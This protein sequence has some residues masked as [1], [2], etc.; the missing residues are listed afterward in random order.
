MIK[1]VIAAA[2]IA[3]T[4]AMAQETQCTSIQD[5]LAALL[6]GGFDP[7]VTGKTEGAVEVTTWARDDAQWVITT[8]AGDT[9]CFVAAGSD[10]K[11]MTGIPNV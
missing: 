5:G 6:Y 8:S 10:F 4:P 9:M 3:A 2:M 11:D 7:I 1:Y